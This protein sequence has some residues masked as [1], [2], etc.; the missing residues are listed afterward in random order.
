M[1]THAEAATE[2]GGD[3]PALPHRDLFDALLGRDGEALDR[4]VADDCQI[5]GPKGF[6]ISKQ[7]WIGTH[8]GDVYELLALEIVDSAVHGWGDSAVTVDLQ[9]SA[10]IFHGERIEGLFRVLSVWHAGD[11]G[12]Q[13][14]GLQYTTASPEVQARRS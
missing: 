7:D 13:L 8:M 5:I 12:W 11:G 2:R 1:T 6:L 4:I 3:T 14:V 9:Q 10:C